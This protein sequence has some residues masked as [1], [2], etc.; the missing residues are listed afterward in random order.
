M[1]R[2]QAE[3]I[4]INKTTMLILCQ[5]MNPSLTGMKVEEI[6]LST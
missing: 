2:K 1:P 6:I 3:L 4:T 5:P